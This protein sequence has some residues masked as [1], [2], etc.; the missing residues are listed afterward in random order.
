[1]S[2]S[3]GELTASALGN[4][5]G[6]TGRYHDAETGLAYFR[7]RY[8]DAELG[9][10]VGRDPMGMGDFGIRGAID[11]GRR[12]AARSA[13]SALG[14]Q[15]TSGNPVRHLD[16]LGLSTCV[17]QVDNE[18]RSCEWLCRIANT[19]EP[20]FMQVCIAALAREKAAALE[21]RRREARNRE[22]RCL[23]GCQERAGQGYERCKWV[24][25]G[26]CREDVCYA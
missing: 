16:P 17:Q 12:S 24:E 14:Y 19:F 8:L 22:L 13:F 2:P 6:F 3:G 15:Y 20:T 21:Q 23:I 18:L 4:E 1:V 9:R 26:V 25:Q 7:A 10:F 5:V 11:L